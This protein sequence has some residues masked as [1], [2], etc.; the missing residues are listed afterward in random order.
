MFAPS[1]SYFI[2][3]S[4]LVRMSYLFTVFGASPWELYDLVTRKARV[5]RVVLATCKVGRPICRYFEKG[6]R[7]KCARDIGDNPER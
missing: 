2:E 1:N 7:K 4:R 6:C 3:K 5:P